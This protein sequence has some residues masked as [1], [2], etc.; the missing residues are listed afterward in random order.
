MT[1]AGQLV[2]GFGGDFK[3]YF[4]YI[5]DS[6]LPQIECAKTFG[7]TN[8]EN[9]QTCSDL[10]NN[11]MCGPKTTILNALLKSDVA[12]SELKSKLLKAI[13]N[14]DHFD[15]THAHILE[16]LIS[17][18]GITN[19]EKLQVVDSIAT[20]ETFRSESFDAVQKELGKP[21]ANID[22]IKA[23]IKINTSVFETGADFYSTQS[24][25]DS[26]DFPDGAIAFQ[27][28]QADALQQCADAYSGR[29]M[30]SCY[31]KSTERLSRSDFRCTAGATASAR[32]LRSDL[33]SCQNEDL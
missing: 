20:V 1:L 26:C 23:A 9:I 31:I 28:A 33:K 14:Y 5:Q 12:D 22:T 19:S 29:K 8:K 30:V 10:Y 2:S 32:Y 17:S 25:R 18:K 4:S 21:F 16:S 11:R 24:A 27:W 7:V 6:S 3:G 13:K 15:K